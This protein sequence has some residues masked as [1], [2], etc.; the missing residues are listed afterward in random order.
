MTVADVVRFY[1]YAMTVCQLGIADK[2]EFESRFSEIGPK[3]FKDL[4][5]TVPTSVAETP[6]L[7]PETILPQATEALVN[8]I[9]EW[10]ESQG[11]E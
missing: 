11:N 8:E 6:T 9:K 7:P 2:E 10:V 4:G 5:M 1:N 3:L